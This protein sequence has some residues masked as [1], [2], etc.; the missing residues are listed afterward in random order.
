VLRETVYIAADIISNLD[1]HG[2][3]LQSFD[4][5]GSTTDSISERYD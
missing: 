4:I 5:V 2:S 3:D 1:F